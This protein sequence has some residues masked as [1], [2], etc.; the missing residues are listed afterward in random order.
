MPKSREKHSDTKVHTIGPGTVAVAFQ[1]LRDSEVGDRD[2]AG[3]N[4][5]ITLG[6]G[7][8]EECNVGDICR[9][10]NVH[11]QGGPRLDDVTS[12]GWIEWG[13]VIK[14]GLD[15]EP[16]NTNLG[17]QTLG[18]SL[19]KY[20]RN[21]CLFTGNIP[22]GIRNA[23]SQEIRIKL[24]K[25]REQLRAGDQVVLYLYGRTVSA[26]ETGTGNFRVIT[27]FNFI[28]HH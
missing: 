24:P 11:I 7:Y 28:N 15:P 1:I 19:T 6:R 4:D 8:G 16:T 17:T 12:T 18:D 20:F 13:V 3:G 27:S 14:K 10:I 25:A 26:T 2:P 5:T 21:E 23:N 22:I 9:Y